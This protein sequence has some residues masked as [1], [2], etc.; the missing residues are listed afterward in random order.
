[1][2]KLSLL[3][4]LFSQTLSRTSYSSDAFVEPSG[5]LS[6]GG[7]LCLGPLAVA[8]PT[9]SRCSAQLTIAGEFG[10]PRGAGLRVAGNRHHLQVRHWEEDLRCSFGLLD[11]AF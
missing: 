1:M 10:V 2:K 5:E 6:A 9:P 11:A 4:L 8:R 7:S 3:T